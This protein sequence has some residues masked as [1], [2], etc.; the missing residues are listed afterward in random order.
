MF[1]G[2]SGADY[3]EVSLRFILGFSSD[4]SQ[5][6]LGANGA[7]SRPARFPEIEEQWGER[8]S[9]QSK[10]AAERHKAN[11]KAAGN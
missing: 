3:A 4:T 7:A 2:P 1:C 10:A 6:P 5:A 8:N 9:K 11:M